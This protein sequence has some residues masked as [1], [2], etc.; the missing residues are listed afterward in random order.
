MSFLSLSGWISMALV[1]CV[2]LAACQQTGSTS[3]DPPNSTD[4]RTREISY[5]VKRTFRLEKG[6][7]SAT[8]DFPEARLNDL[9]WEEDTLV[10]LIKPENAPINSSP[11]YA[12]QIWAKDSQ[13]VS[14][15]LRYEEAPHRYWPKMSRD[16][17]TFMP[18]DSADVAVDTLTGEAHLRLEL[19]PE[20][21][22][23]CGQEYFPSAHTYAWEE[24]LVQEFGA[25]KKVAG[26]S[27]LGKPIHCLQLNA[28]KPVETLVIIGRQHPPEATGY[29]AMQHFVRQILTDSL[30][31]QPFLQR[32]QVLLFPMI[33]PDG[34]DQGHWRHGAGGVDLNRD[35]E[36]FRQPEPKV[37]S[38]YLTGLQQSGSIKVWLGLDFHSTQE[39]MYYIFDEDLESNFP[40]FTRPWLAEIDSMFPEY[41][42]VIEP[43]PMTSPSA[44]LFFFQELGAEFV[45]YEV[46]DET[47]RA[48][49]QAKAEAAA[50]IMMRKMLE[51]TG[52][53][54]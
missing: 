50:R 36:Y 30:Y 10:A 42:P 37:V 31:A 33:N 20:R 25:R 16:G 35:W 24:N 3:Y 53:E 48:F 49:I 21:L 8:N 15:T 6:S 43:G 41:E 52:M 44:K 47:P 46:G 23:I 54:S 27:T 13:E 1:A 32:F 19:G 22:W 51:R 7:I 34:I 45:T 11:W 12:F 39:D 2:C 17:E 9:F 28:A 14:L 38:D 5:Q 40:A 18:M 4:T 29:I 26:Y